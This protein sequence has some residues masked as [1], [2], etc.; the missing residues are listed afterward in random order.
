MVLNGD[1]RLFLL[2]LSSCNLRVFYMHEA[3]EHDNRYNI[4]PDKA[5]FFNQKV[6]GPG[7]SCSKRR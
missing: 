7:P 4:A 1:L 6:L 2:I 3:Y 5:R